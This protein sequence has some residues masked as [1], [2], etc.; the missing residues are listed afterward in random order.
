MSDAYAVR[1]IKQ[2]A[3]EWVRLEQRR[4]TWNMT[5]VPLG[6]VQKLETSAFRSRIVTGE[7]F[8]ESLNARLL[9][10]PTTFQV[11]SDNQRAVV[12]CVPISGAGALHIETEKV[13]AVLSL[14]DERRTERAVDPVSI[15]AIMAIVTIVAIVALTTTAI[16]IITETGGEGQVEVKPE[17][18]PVP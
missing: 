9:S 1:Q 16:V 3:P 5:T 15:V 17:P 6:D 4:G 13:M 2:E 18:E 11:K 12:R 10:E 8:L 14:V 7:A